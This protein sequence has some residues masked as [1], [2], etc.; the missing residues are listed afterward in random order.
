MLR[1]SVFL[2]TMIVMAA[3]ASAKGAEVS[4]ILTFYLQSSS[5]Y[6]TITRKLLVGIRVGFFAAPFGNRLPL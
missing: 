5:L 4:E 3:S 2:M 6:F 1:T